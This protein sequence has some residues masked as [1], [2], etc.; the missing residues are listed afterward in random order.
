MKKIVLSHF[1]ISKDFSNGVVNYSKAM[2][3]VLGDEYILIANN[4]SIPQ[5]QFRYKVLR[6]VTKNYLPSE[7]IVE[8]AESQA[9][10][11]YIP[12]NYNVHIRM[13]CP[14]H[15]YKRV[16]K[17]VPDE[18]RYSEEVRALSKAKAVSSPSY[19]ML[20]Y[21]GDDLDIDNIHVFKNPIEKELTSISFDDKDI[22]V[23][24]LLRFNRLKGS[25]FINPILRLLPENYNVMLVGKQE[26]PFTLDSRVKCNV[27]ILPHVEGDEKY[28]LLERSK[29]SISLSKFENCS[30]VILES[31]S[32]SVPIVC[33]DVGGNG[34]IA[35]NPVVNTIPY[36]NIF[37]FSNRIV[38][39]CSRINY[40][41]ED[42]FSDAYKAINV[43]FKNGVRHIEGLFQGQAKGIYRGID[44]RQENRRFHP[45]PYE[46]EG[47][48]W[49]EL[50]AT[51]FH[52]CYLVKSEKLLN[53]LILFL[54]N[55]E[56][57]A[58]IISSVKPKDSPGNIEIINFDWFNHRGK[59]MDIIKDVRADVIAFEKIDFTCISKENEFIHSLKVPCVGIEY[60]GIDDIVYFDREA[61]IFTS[62]LRSLK[63]PETK[64]NIR[65]L[66]VRLSEILVVV[67]S[68]YSKS[69][70]ESLLKKLK[71]ILQLK[72]NISSA[73]IKSEFNLNDDLS[74]FYFKYEEDN[75]EFSPNH[76]I[77]IGAKGLNKYLDKELALYTLT[78]SI[79]DYKGVCI[80]SDIGSFKLSEKI[81]INEVNREHLESIIN[82]KSLSKDKRDSYW[83][84][85]ELYSAINRFSFRESGR[86]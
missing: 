14:F 54:E 21:L 42:L 8:A 6:D 29:V 9:T 31:I 55:A 46:L 52:A 32:C 4:K 50:E 79:Y 67:D 5:D 83:L 70:S 44:F 62:Y 1:K 85:D 71:D 77:L 63:F 2:K 65:H 16:I 34:E 48:S 60:C 56:I 17:Q 45:L 86:A 13:H 59:L 49:N 51:P 76:V 58:T 81:E 57:S 43:D 38:E 80:K 72:Y 40:P 37:A 25:E 61:S 84:I 82:I 26:E 39:L 74:D 10:S 78:D 20:D 47:R 27:T 7:V 28:R 66:N 11:L 3:K 33:W 30:M 18:K 53:H 64:N 75:F 15:L 68:S 12:S 19:G 23:I 24:F 69:L 73:A 36:E 41:S 22:D 35:R